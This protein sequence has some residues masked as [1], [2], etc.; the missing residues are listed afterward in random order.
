ML[1]DAARELAQCTD[2]D[3]IPPADTY[4]ADGEWLHAQLTRSREGYKRFDR[5]GDDDARYD[6]EG[7][8]T[9]Q[10]LSGRL[11][12]LVGSFANAKPASPKVFASMLAHHVL[13]VEPTVCELESACRALVERP[14]PFLTEVGEV[15]A[16]VRSEKTKWAAR[17]RAFDRVDE[18][19]RK[20]ITAIPKAKAR[21]EEAVKEE[22]ARKWVEGREQHEHMIARQHELNEKARAAGFHACRYVQMFGLRET[23]PEECGRHHHHGEELVGF[24]LGCYER[25]RMERLRT[26]LLAARHAM[27]ALERKEAAA[28]R[29]QLEAYGNALVQA[30]GAVLPIKT[31]DALAALAARLGS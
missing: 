27:R 30:R 16:A 17:R 6:E 11:G 4:E 13:A 12:F 20:I 14:K 9:F 23:L 3:R 31:D 1:E 19:R 7:D 29:P 18:L 21:A 2:P 15:V 10:H 26:M 5:D 24:V 8:I 25:A 22:A 28:A